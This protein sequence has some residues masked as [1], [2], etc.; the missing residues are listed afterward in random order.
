VLICSPAFALDVGLYVTD[1]MDPQTVQIK[2]LGGEISTTA[3]LFATPGEYEP[4]S[5][6]VRPD[7]RVEEMFMEAGDLSGPA[8]RIERDRVR[9]CSVEGFHGGDYD[10]VMELGRS[11]HMPAMRR[12][13]FWVIVHVPEDARPGTYRGQVTVTSRGKPIGRLD[14]ELEVLPFTLEEPPY[15]LG[16]NY[17]SP[18]D[19]EA[20]TAHLR[21]MREHGA[22]TVAPLYNFHLPVHDDDTAEIGAFIEA[23]KAAGYTKPLFFAS[24]MSLLGRLAGYG[25]VDSR[26]FQRKYLACMRTLWEETSRHDVPVIFSI[27]D[28]FTNKALPGIE[29]AE[30]LARLAYEELPQIC[31]TSDM[32]GYLEVMA[33]A[34]YLDIATFNN[35]WDGIDGHN[36]G[37]RLINRE[38]I[39]EVQQTGAIPWFVNG[40]RGRF[41]YGL[42]FW[43][44]A[45]YG[46]QGKV[47]WY[48]NLGDNSRGSVVRVDGPKVWPTVTYE[49]SREGVDDLKY[50]LK[51]EQLVADAK[52]SGRARP[53]VRAAE[54]LIKRIGD[55]II[56]NWTA[57]REGGEVFPPEDLGIP[58]S[59]E[60][61][62]LG[63][64][65]AV[66]RAMAEAIVGLQEGR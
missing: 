14:L 66:R 61:A 40:G 15:A 23:Y 42:F 33:M 19:P 47:E 53:E 3:K 55:G 41:P 37:R 38:F 13:L 29:F 22:T 11:W 46:V 60:A 25:P 16:Y 31:T 8:G 39:T 45:G 32:N 12:E 30:K 56:D 21:D 65:N 18:K 64:Y 54:Q 17:S 4:V 26:R 50:M 36:E 48:Y 1:Y 5:F 49:R 7:E 2:P 28:E 63:R 27:G 57:Y 35:G 44:M 59:D 52:Q 9:V 10:I 24:P 58:S 20:L 51:L 43:K 34:P 6:A 62:G